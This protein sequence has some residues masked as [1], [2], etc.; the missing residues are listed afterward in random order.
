MRYSCIVVD[1]IINALYASNRIMI[2]GGVNL[3]HHSIWCGTQAINGKRPE[4][5]IIAALLHDFGH[6]LIDVDESNYQRDRIHA[7]IS[8]SWLS[9]WFPD[10]VCRPIALHTKAK[11]YLCRID[12]QYYQRLQK[13]SQLSLRN[14]GLAMNENEAYLF[15]CDRYFV[16]SLII[17]HYDDEPYREQ[18]L[19]DL[20]YFREI[21]ITILR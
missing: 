18:T 11:R 14:Q 20:Q 6:Y 16:D 8:A 12:K 21:L 15:K 5:L 3:Y 2:E 13:G 19:F 4:A 10:D 7:E 1:F 17:R 9:R